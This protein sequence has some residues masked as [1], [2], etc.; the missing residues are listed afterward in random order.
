MQL[1]DYDK[2]GMIIES[3]LKKGL[4]S[5]GQIVSNSEVQYLMQIVDTDKNNQISYSELLAFA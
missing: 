2:D 5:K 3:E 4:E 1:L